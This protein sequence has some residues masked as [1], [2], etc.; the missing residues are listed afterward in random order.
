MVAASC[1][2]LS[3]VAHAQTVDGE[4]TLPG[5]ITVALEHNPTYVAAK[6]SLAISEG[7]AK[8]A[9]GQ[10]QPQ[11]TAGVEES[12]ESGSTSLDPVVTLSQSVQAFHPLLVTPAYPLPL[13]ATALADLTE[14]QAR[15]KLTK[16]HNDLVFSVT[17]GYY[18]VLAAKN[19]VE[20]RQAGV[21]SARAAKTVAEANLAA[22]TGTNLDVLKADLEVANAELAL[23][24][25]QNAVTQ[26]KADFFAVLGVESPA[27]P[28][29]FAQ[30]PETAGLSESVQAFQERALQGNPAL[31]DA[32]LSVDRA[33]SELNEARRGLLP[34]VSLSTTYTAG[35]LGAEAS[36]E[37]LTGEAGWAI[38]LNPADSASS[39]ASDSTNQWISLVSLT[40]PLFDAGVQAAVV[41]QSEL[42]L[43]QAQVTYNQVV[44]ETKTAV[45]TAYLAVADAKHSL[46]ALEKATTQAAEA[47]RLAELRVRNGAG[48]MNELIDANR[49]LVEAQVNLTQARF[50]YQV[51][52]ASLRKAV[53]DKE[54]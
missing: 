36:W 18:A 5:S 43:Q 6:L 17:E 50:D 2:I 54:E 20:V 49:D 7:G 8:E 26:A 1:F 23:A 15:A 24:K 35:H 41:Q 48:T 9:R 52:L 34:T 21:E 47:R 46:D 22:G 51:A 12:L 27:T 3:G 29:T 10:T 44:A 11:L 45:L 16:A 33:T 53:G 39:T 38:K 32:Q 28:V 37:P 25:A 13:P 42:A 4:L 19:L 31:V 14:R 30:P 40:Y